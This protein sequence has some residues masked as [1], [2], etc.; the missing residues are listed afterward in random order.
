MLASNN[1]A[2]TVPEIQGGLT[3]AWASVIYLKNLNDEVIRRLVDGPN[4]YMIGP[5]PQK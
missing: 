5:V 3:Q 2:M 4:E 1:R